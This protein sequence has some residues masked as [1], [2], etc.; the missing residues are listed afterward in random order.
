PYLEPG[1]TV[2][3]WNG[4]HRRFLR[5]NDQKDID[6]W[7]GGQ[8]GPML[9]GD[10][11]WEKF[12]VVDAGYGEV[13]LYCK[14]HKRFLSMNADNMYAS[15]ETE[16][17]LKDGW[18]WQRFAVVPAPGGKIA[19]HNRAHNRFV[20][21]T[22]HNVQA[23]GPNAP[24]D[25][26]AGWTWE[27]FHVVQVPD[28]KAGD[29]PLAGMVS[30]FR[31]E[32]A[33]VAW[34]SAVGSY[35]AFGS[36]GVHR[37]V[38]AGHGAARPVAYMAGDH[39]Q[40]YNFG[41][42]LSPTYTV[43]SVS[44]YT[45]AHK[46]RVLQT[47][48]PANWLHGHWHGKAGVCHYGEWNTPHDGSS[49]TDWVV[50]CGSNGHKVFDGSKNNIAISNGHGFDREYHLKVNPQDGF[51]EFSDFG[52]ME[53]ITWNRVLSDAEMMTTIDYLQKKLKLGTA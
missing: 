5:M 37:K 7:P 35:E 24:Q 42:V 20:Q 2:G 9:P 25:F 29:P 48:L 14:H 23:K 6:Y 26:E 27:I 4:L 39:G 45:G 31:S 15:D 16:M 13:A 12:T 32:D 1:T 34:R 52:V 30:W 41:K 10:W 11:I 40:T 17:S 44:R 28:T 38:E 53:V 49:T 50:L 33:E 51:K 21:M 19:L 8:V 36:D 43:C 18:T 22:E 3:L 47:E 46:K